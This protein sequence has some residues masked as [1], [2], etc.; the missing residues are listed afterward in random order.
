MH[1][2]LGANGIIA[3]TLSQ[4]LKNI[5][6]HIR[7][8]SRHPQKV[9]PNDELCVADLLDAKSTANA[10]AGSEVV[11]LVAGLPYNTKAW[12][13]QWPQVMRNTIDACK[14]HQARLVFFDNVYAYGLV[15]GVM[16]EQTPFNPNSQ[17]GEVRARIASML[18]D[19]MRS[20][21]L[22][23]MITRCA[24]YYG[25]NATNSFLYITVIQRIKAGKTPQWIGKLNTIHTYTFTPDAANALA[26]LAQK[27][28]A[29]G[30]TWHL[31]TS[32]ELLSAE[33]FVRMVCNLAGRPYQIQ[34]MPGW[35]QGILEYLVPV[36]RE[37]KEMMYQ[38]NH[39]YRFDSSKI[40]SAYE[41]VATPYQQGIRSCLNSD[42]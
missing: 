14:Q 17:K 27:P 28:E 26:V 9:N 38:F 25:P 35:L 11:Y 16:T 34:N 15:D 5:T 31:P 1:T 7:Q 19:E 41:L 3:K 33:Q 40:E 13:E 20:A 23:A 39:D 4:S 21:N 42:S 18:L 6:P 37:N 24:D 32:K 2:I 30:Q 8:V 12:R 36:L 10:V 29:Y 22:Q